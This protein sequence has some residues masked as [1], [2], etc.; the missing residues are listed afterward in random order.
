MERDFENDFDTKELEEEQKR[1]ES[2]QEALLKFS[3]N[4]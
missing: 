3:F 2:E 1:M 4:G